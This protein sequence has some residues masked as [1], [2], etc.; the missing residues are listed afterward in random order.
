V[1]VLS[2]DEVFA[3]MRTHVERERRRHLLVAEA[4]LEHEEEPAKTSVADALDVYGLTL[5]DMTYSLRLLTELAAA[6]ASVRHELDARVAAELGNGG[7]AQFGGVVVRYGVGT[8]TLHVQR[9]SEADFFRYLEAPE[10]IAR[11][12]AVGYVRK[13]PLRAVA[14]RRGTDFSTIVSTFLDKRF[15][16]PHVAFIPAAESSFDLKEGDVIKRASDVV[17]EAT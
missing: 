6:L 3:L 7:A 5:E 2:I 9:G 1:S 11:V 12:V 4:R 17:D 16:R 15:S 8:P 13:T 14:E 10:D